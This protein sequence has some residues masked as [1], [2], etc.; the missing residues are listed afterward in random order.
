MSECATHPQV[1]LSFTAGHFIVTYSAHVCF[2]HASPTLW[3]RCVK[4]NTLFFFNPLQFYKSAK[5][6]WLFGAYFCLPL[7]CTAIFYTLMTCEMLRKKNGVQIALSDHLKQV[8]LLNLYFNIGT[9]LTT[10]SLKCV[11]LCIV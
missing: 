11:L 10:E 2:L 1:P 7:A 6:W 8:L 3:R 9:S 4:S 5:D